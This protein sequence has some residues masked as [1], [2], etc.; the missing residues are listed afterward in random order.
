M[1]DLEQVS[2]GVILTTSSIMLL[3]TDAVAVVGWAEYLKKS[4]IVK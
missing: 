3:G 2:S 1:K 4:K